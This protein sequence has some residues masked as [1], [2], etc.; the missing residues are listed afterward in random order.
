MPPRKLSVVDVNTTDV[1]DDTINTESNIPAEVL[2]EPEP[3]IPGEVLDEPVIRKTKTRIQNLI[4]CPKCGKMMLEK[5]LK[6]SHA[7]TC[8]SIP[9]VPPTP[10][11]SPAP[12]IEKPKRGRPLKVVPEPTPVHVEDKEEFTPPIR[13]R[14]SDGYNG[15]VVDVSKQNIHQDYGVGLPKTNYVRNSNRL[16]ERIQK[17]QS[18]FS[19]AF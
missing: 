12:T 19:K 2:D 11:P 15:L 1:E 16:Q 6:Y 5:T 8:G 14:I 9:S 3:N 7:K 4:E 13:N 18:V 10:P 17:M